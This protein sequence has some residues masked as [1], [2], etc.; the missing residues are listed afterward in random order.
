MQCP[1][2]GYENQEDAQYCNLCQYSFYKSQQQSAPPDKLFADVENR[3]NPS[4]V[5]AEELSWFQRH[6]N[7]TW[8]IA[9]ITVVPAFI[10]LANILLFIT[11]QPPSLFYSGDVAYPFYITILSYLLGFVSTFIVGGWALV[12][13]ARSLWWLAVLFLGPIGIIIFLCVRNKSN[14]IMPDPQSVPDMPP[15]SAQPYRS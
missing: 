1:S 14:E 13:K 12:R 11:G 3:L 10:I 4:G 8:I 15:T 7:L 9:N 6:L 5:S 2:C